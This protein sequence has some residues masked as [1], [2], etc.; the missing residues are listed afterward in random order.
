MNY[1]QPQE[2]KG[3]LFL[4]KLE[5]NIWMLPVVLPSLA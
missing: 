1:R 3:A 2:A 4:I 5:R